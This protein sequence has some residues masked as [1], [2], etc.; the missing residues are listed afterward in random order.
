M[1]GYSYTRGW[2]RQ[3][4]DLQEETKHAFLWEN[5]VLHDLGTLGGEKSRASAINGA[6]Q[7]VGTSTPAAGAPHAFLWEN[8]TMRDLGPDEGESRAAAINDAG[9]VAGDVYTVETHAALWDNGTLQDLARS[10][11][12]TPKHARSMLGGRSSDTV[13]L[14]S[15]YRTPSCG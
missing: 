2:D 14:P 8:G 13:T 9:Q 12:P 10:A 15:R 4:P 7:I 3:N 6:G 11:E 1:I 5:G